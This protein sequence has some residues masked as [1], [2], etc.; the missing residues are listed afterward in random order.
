MTTTVSVRNAP[1][2]NKF[3]ENKMK[4]WNAISLDFFASVTLEG[5]LLEADHYPKLGRAF[6]TL[7][8]PY[9]TEIIHPSASASF[10]L[11]NEDIF[12]S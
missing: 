1:N 11:F 6:S 9:G 4:I 7:L 3:N 5:D 8:F 2:L 10:S 12:Q